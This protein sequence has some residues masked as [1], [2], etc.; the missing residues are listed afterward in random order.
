MRKI[1]VGVAT[2]LL[3][4][5]VMAQGGPSGG[6]P[7]G[8][9]PPGGRPPGG[10]PPGRPPEMKP[11]KREKLD[12]VVTGMFRAADTDRDG[13][14]TVDELRT[15]FSVRRDM[16]IRARFEKIDTNRDSNIS[17]PEFLAWQQQMGTA[18][19]SEDQPVAFRGGAASEAIQ[20]DLDDRDGNFLAML[21][22]PL[23]TI[24]V[25]N[26]NTNYDRGM[27]LDELLVYERKRFDGADLNAD[28]ELAMDEL[29]EMARR[30]EGQGPGSMGGPGGFG[31][32]GGPGPRGAP[33]PC[34]PGG[35]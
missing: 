18:A 24:T 9:G 28:G 4:G 12:K 31:G 15:I 8:G 23:S 21:I 6:G 1:L 26:A 3:A 25:V 5:Q 20:P 30:R 13:L 7:P 34:G 33:P 2:L 19:L 14:V 22:E 27:S 10:R 16:L 17:L 11:V 29:R 32:P 35:C